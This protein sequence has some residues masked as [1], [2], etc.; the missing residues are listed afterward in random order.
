M[1]QGQL[2]TLLLALTVPLLVIQIWVSL[3]GPPVSSS[4]SPPSPLSWTHTP[5]ANGLATKSAPIITTRTSSDAAAVRTG[6]PRWPATEGIPLQPLWEFAAGVAAGTA[7]TIR[8][9]KQRSRFPEILYAVDAAGVWVSQ[10]IRD[11]SWKKMIPYRLAP[12]EGIFRLAWKRLQN[13]ATAASTDNS[14]KWPTLRRTLHTDAGGGGSFP[15]LV[16]YGDYKSCNYQNWQ[17]RYS[18][19]LFTTCAAVNC[20]HAFPL[21][22]YKS[23]RNSQPTPEDWTVQMQNYAQTYP[24]ESKLPRVVWRGSLSGPNSDYQ[25]DRWRLVKLVHERRAS[26]EEDLFDIGLTSIP[27][28]HDH[29]QLN[30]SQ[31]GGLVSP[32]KPMEAFQ[33]YIGILDIDG[34]SWSSRFGALLCYNSVV[35]KVEPAYVDYFHPTLQ[36]WKHYVP[37][38]RDLS[39]LEQQ[40]AFC[41]DADNQAAVRQIVATAND[42]C[43][44]HMAWTSI[45]ES[46]LD[47]WEA[48][49]KLLY[50][51]DDNWTEEWKKARSSSN[52]TSFFRL[53]KIHHKLDKASFQG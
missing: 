32:L 33:R 16:W 52:F 24:W 41:T 18:I 7:T 35:L 9:P 42:W 15:F 6:F 40:A 11:R 8:W 47:I 51:A 50:A 43:R 25:S 14:S 26:L 30:V 17:G 13:D 38:Q 53:T 34:N 20:T 39:D 28:R 22:T 1:R 12:T 4:S 37:V 21:P 3:H 23:I 45:A 31:V 10:T 2:S 48:Y 5:H 44:Q 19:P 49:V 36:P 27:S 29:L 46:V